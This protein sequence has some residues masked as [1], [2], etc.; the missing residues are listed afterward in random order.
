MNDL[1]ANQRREWANDRAKLAEARAEVERLR[2]EVEE[3][4]KSRSEYISR[5]ADLTRKYGEREA[6]EKE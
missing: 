2:A 3:L 4:R 5:L 6:E 1:D